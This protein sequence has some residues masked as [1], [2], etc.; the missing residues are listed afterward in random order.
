MGP[1]KYVQGSI[2]SLNGKRL[3]IGSD[4]IF[5]Y[6]NDFT[7]GQFKSDFKLPVSNDYFYKQIFYNLCDTDEDKKAEYKTLLKLN[8]EDYRRTVLQIECNRGLIEN[9]EV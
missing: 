3:I 4:D 9:T 1:D 8:D 5:E 7:I 2:F 6:I